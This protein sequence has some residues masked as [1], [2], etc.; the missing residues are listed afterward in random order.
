M[1]V[2]EKKKS[3]KKSLDTFW[4]KKEILKRTYLK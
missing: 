2:N 1:N 4:D 3:C